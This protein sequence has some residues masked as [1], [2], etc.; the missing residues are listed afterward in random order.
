MF[1]A[2]SISKSRGKTSEFLAKMEDEVPHP[3]SACCFY[4]AGKIH[5]QLITISYLNNACTGRQISGILHMFGHSA[6]F[7]V[8]VICDSH[9]HRLHVWPHICSSLSDYVYLSGHAL[10]STVTHTLRPASEVSL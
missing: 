9:P 6:S 2:L 10:M 3:V 4:V 1:R 5:Q 7:I 8:T